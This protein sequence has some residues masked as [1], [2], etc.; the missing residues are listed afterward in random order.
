MDTH[1]RRSVQVCGKFDLRKWFVVKRKKLF[2]THDKLSR[3]RIDMR[4]N[5][6][7]SEDECRA[8]AYFS[9][10][11]SYDPIGHPEEK[12]GNLIRV[13]VQACRPKGSRIADRNGYITVDEL[14]HA[15]ASGYWDEFVNKLTRHLIKRGQDDYNK[16]YLRIFKYGCRRF[17]L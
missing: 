13:Y 2:T 11:P 15:Y 10:N 3:L 14:N 1:T 5:T 12:S 4:I 6:N 7:A 9:F 16:Y 17:D 8:D